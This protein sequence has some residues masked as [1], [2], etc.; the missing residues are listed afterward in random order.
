MSEASPKRTS[1]H[2][3]LKII[4]SILALLAIAAKLEWPELKIDAVVFGLFVVAVLPWLAPLVK[5]VELPG[6]LKIELQ[7][8]KEL[9]EEA[10]G[11]AESARQRAEWALLKTQTKPTIHLPVAARELF[12]EDKH[13]E[14]INRATGL[15]TSYKEI[16]EKM[17]SGPAR[18]QEMTMI[19]D[20]MTNLAREYPGWDAKG[21]LVNPDNGWRLMAYSH[22]FA[23]P[24]FSLLEP[25]VSSLFEKAKEN[26]P[27]E[28]Y[29]SIMALQKIMS[30]RGELPIQT[31]IKRQ[32]RAFY[33]SLQAGT[34]RH[35]EMQGILKELKLI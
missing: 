16:R 35:Y 24:D 8:I 30:L 18:T 23:L 17:S 9:A 20:R 22:I 4:V 15:V 29:W 6:G 14:W 25:F 3:W 34:D 1:N 10:K 26:K 12:V 2:T 21:N 19:V 32:L 33:D 5:S 28:Q 7:E 27:F 31:S 13:L 11:G